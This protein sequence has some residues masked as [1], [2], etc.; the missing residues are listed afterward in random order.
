MII[1]KDN[2]RQFAKKIFLLTL[3][4]LIA[5]IFTLTKGCDLKNDSFAGFPIYFSMAIIGV[6]AFIISVV[7]NVKIDD[8]KII[9]NTLTGKKTLKICE[10]SYYL[11]KQK[12]IEYNQIVIYVRGKKHTIF[13]KYWREVINLIRSKVENN[14]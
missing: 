9:I 12:N 7:Y 1:L 4:M 11:Y 6:I 3:P 10:V 14:D 8:E 13:T 2:I 5:T